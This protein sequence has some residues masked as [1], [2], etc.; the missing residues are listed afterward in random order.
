M[1]HSFIPRKKR[2]KKKHVFL[3]HFGTYYVDEVTKLSLICSGKEY[4][5]AFQKIIMS[6]L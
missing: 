4:G 1:S 2:K 5:V 6:S 3:E